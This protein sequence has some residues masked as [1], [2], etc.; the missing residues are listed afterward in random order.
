[1]YQ[2]TLLF[3]Y[4]YFLNNLIYYY[5]LLYIHIGAYLKLGTFFK[6]KASHTT[7]HKSDKRFICYFYRDNFV[8]IV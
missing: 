1:M 2:L 6:R 4:M 3:M 8:T 5:V 7:I